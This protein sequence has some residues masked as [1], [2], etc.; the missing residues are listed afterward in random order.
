VEKALTAKGPRYR[1]PFRRRREGKTDYYARK[2]LILSNLPR[3]VARGSLRHMIVQV[4]K[5]KVEGDEIVTSAHSKEL[6]KNF[7]WKGACGNLPAA[8]LTGFLCGLR[9]SEKGVKKAILDIGLKTPVKGSRVFAVLK[10][11]LDAGVEVPHGKEILPDESRLK[12]E[13]IANYAEKLA[14]EDPE[15]YKRRFSEYLSKK[16][17]PE[18][19]PEHFLK[20]KE[21]ILAAFRKPKKVVKPKKKVKAKAVKGK[22]KVPKAPKATKKRKAKTTSKKRSKKKETKR[23][24]KE[25]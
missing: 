2:A 24:E 22:A 10:G 14:A 9:A 19:L 13:H 1:V 6:T 23:E 21:K 25:K 5:A 20:V 16:L 17:R 18:K 8:Y 15:E 12:G 3:I 7:G 4:V 11:V